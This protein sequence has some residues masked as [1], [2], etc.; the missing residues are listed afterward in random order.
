MSFDL[1]ELWGGLVRWYQGHS[2]RDRRIIAAV[3]VAIGLYL[4]DLVLVEPVRAY[5]Q[6]VADEI[7]AGHDELERAARFVAAAPVLKAERDDL[8]KRLDQAKTRLLPGDTGTLGA[9]ALQEKANAIANEKGLT[10][11]STQVM[12]EEAADPFRKVAVRLTMSAEPKALAEFLAAVEYGQQLSVPFIEVSRRGATPGK[13]GP[14]TLQATVEVS[15]YVRQAK[16]GKPADAES[17]AEAEAA[18]AAAPEGPATSE[19]EAAP[20]GSVPTSTIGT[21]PGPVPAAVPGDTPPGASIPAVPAPTAGSSMPPSGAAPTTAPPPP[22]LPAL[23][24]GGPL[25]SPSPP[26][27]APAPPPAPGA[28]PPTPATVPPP[29]AGAK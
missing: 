23:P 20:P 24:A 16:G 12:K 17:E 15:G 3:G 18:Q 7:A 19:G 25:P 29:P 13:A 22:T 5:R 21:P 14:R 11:Q 26:P 4:L 10:I 8:R 27:S 28:L 1:R 2:Q 9:A 6:G